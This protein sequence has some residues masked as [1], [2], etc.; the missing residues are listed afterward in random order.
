MK[1]GGG[2]SGEGG[3]TQK[4]DRKAHSSSN[5]CK[6]INNCYDLDDDDP[7]AARGTFFSD[8]MCVAW[9]GLV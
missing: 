9:P 1:R 6:L 8:N 3:K 7:T 4:R 2:G 5:Q